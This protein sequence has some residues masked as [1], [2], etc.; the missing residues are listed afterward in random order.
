MLPTHSLPLLPLHTA[1]L[2]SAH[3]RAHHLCTR[4]AFPARTVTVHEM[5]RPFACYCYMF[6]TLPEHIVAQCAC[7]IAADAAAETC[8]F[9]MLATGPGAH[10]HSS[11]LQLLLLQVPSWVLLHLHIRNSTP[12]TLHLAQIGPMGHDLGGANFKATGTFKF[13]RQHA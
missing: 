10:H 13:S 8:I 2:C 4:T 12:D 3:A 6:Q 5:C 11:Q 9:S 7:Y 1:V